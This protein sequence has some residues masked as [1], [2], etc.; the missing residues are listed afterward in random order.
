[1]LFNHPKEKIVMTKKNSTLIKE[2]VARRWGKL[3]NMP[4]LTENW[5]EALTEED[6]AEEEV[7]AMDDMEKAEM[8]DDPEA[9]MDYAEGDL[10]RADAG[11]TIDLESDDAQAL[12]QKVAQT[13]ADMV[14]E[15]VEFVVDAEGEGAEDVGDDLDIEIEDDEVPAMG[16][17]SYNRDDLTEEDGAMGGD[18]S[19]TRRRKVDKDDKDPKADAKARKKYDKSHK[20]H[21]FR[22]GDQLEKDADFRESLDLEVVDDEALTE[23]VLKRVVERLLSRK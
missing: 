22:D 23:A 13:V 16:M 19:K 10:E 1:L 2:S 7:E 6:P 21:G 8:G 3:A 11:D 20:G 9:E 14:A 5:L 18:Q 15:P 12:I 4:S 17:D